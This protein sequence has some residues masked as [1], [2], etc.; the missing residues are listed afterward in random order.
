MLLKKSQTAR[1]QFA[2]AKNL[3]DD[4]RFGATLNHVTEVVSEFFLKQ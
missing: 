2:F 3:T 4:Y 1:R